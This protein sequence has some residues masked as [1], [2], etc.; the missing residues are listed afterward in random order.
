MTIT[1]EEFLNQIELADIC[2]DW[3][4]SVLNIITKRWTTGGQR[5]KSCWGGEHGGYYARE[6]EPEP[7][8]K[9]LDKILEIFAPQ[10]TYLQYKVLVDEMIAMK[11]GEDNDWYGNTEEYSEKTLSLV[12]LYNY[13]CKNGFIDA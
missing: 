3:S 6:V 10:I 5:A 7:E 9:E 11:M 4:G 12:Q 13:L 1:L 8:F 2:N